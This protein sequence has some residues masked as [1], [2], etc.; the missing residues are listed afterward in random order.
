MNV[1][2]NA[3]YYSIHDS[4]FGLHS[5]FLS[6]L[7]SL[8]HFL[9]FCPP[10]SFPPFPH[11]PFYIFPSICSTFPNFF[12]KSSSSL[13]QTFFISLQLSSFPPS[14][15]FFIPFLLPSLPF[16]NYSFFMA[17]LIPIHFFTNT[18][19]FLLING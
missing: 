6:N 13:P 18:T 17:S 5:F 7:V 15:Y 3:C 14:P 10:L 11:P 12:P 19:N 1:W 8:I 2:M 9:Y 16:I 4:Y